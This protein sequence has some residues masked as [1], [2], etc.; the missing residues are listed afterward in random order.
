[1]LA[2]VA[3][4]L[5]AVALVIVA[6]VPTMLAKLAVPVAV[7]LVPVAFPKRRLE[8]EAVRAFKRVEKRLEVVALVTVALVA[9][10]L[11]VTVLEAAMFVT[12]RE[13]AFKLVMLVVARLV[14]PL[15]VRLPVEMELST[16]APS[17]QATVPFSTLTLIRSL[18]FT[19]AL[20]F[21]QR[22]RL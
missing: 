18:I 4:R 16:L 11:S 6:L 14:V 19:T 21:I 8:M 10:I 20:S 9:K 22:H 7:M 1:M 15:A 5:V 2:L 13:P 3:N 12:E 17:L